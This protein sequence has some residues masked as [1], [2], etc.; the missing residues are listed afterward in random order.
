LIRNY[1]DPLLWEEGPVNSSGL[2]CPSQIR[3]A[4]RDE[5]LAKRLGRFS[6]AGI[7]KRG[8]PLG[9]HQ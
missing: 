5:A 4:T 2:V 9:S 1:G 7:Q 6:K 8:F 3:K